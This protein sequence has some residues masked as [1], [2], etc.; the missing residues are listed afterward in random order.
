MLSPGGKVPK[1]R[2]GTGTPS[3]VGRRVLTVVVAVLLLA[4]AGAAAWWF[5]VRSAPGASVT[6]CPTAAAPAAAA[7]AVAPVGASRVTVNVFNATGRTG[8]ATTVATAMRSRHFV[9][10]K[11]AN[12]PLARTV[13]GPAEVRAGPSGRSAAVT[14]ASQVKGAVLVPDRR[15]DATVDLV[16]G[17]TYTT[18]R[19]PAQVRAALKPA[20]SPTTPATAARPA[21]AATRPAGCG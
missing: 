21:T 1:R 12:D 18:L 11:V 7:S 8:L 10:A 16:I 20:A 15:K 14:V 13:A 2:P 5:G 9:V 6:A 4:G 17:A 3:G 19:T